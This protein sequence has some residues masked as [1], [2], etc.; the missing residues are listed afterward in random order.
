[1]NRVAASLAVLAIAL[2]PIGHLPVDNSVISPVQVKGSENGI[3]GLVRPATPVP[4]M[5]APFPSRLVSDFLSCVSA[6]VPRNEEALLR[7]TVRPFRNAA[8]PYFYSCPGDDGAMWIVGTPTRVHVESADLRRLPL[9]V[10]PEPSLPLCARPRVA[11]PPA[12][13][14]RQACTREVRVLNKT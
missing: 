8:V 12:I 1:L 6:P 9:N 3:V 7:V 13:P 5:T 4:I 10:L 11:G 14:T 2:L